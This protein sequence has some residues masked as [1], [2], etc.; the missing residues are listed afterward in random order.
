[1]AGS[2]SSEGA[3]GGS[4]E[5]YKPPSGRWKLLVAIAA[6][7]VITNFVTGITAYY[8]AQPAAT[9]PALCGGGGGVSSSAAPAASNAASV[10]SAEDTSPIFTFHVDPPYKTAQATIT[11]IGPWAPGGEFELFRPVLENFTAATGV[12]VTYENLRQE[13]LTTILPAQFASGQTPGDVIFMTTSFIKAN[14]QHIIKETGNISDSDFIPGSLD[15]VKVGSDPYGGVYTG[16]VKPGFWYRKSFFAAHNL[17]VPTTYTDFKALLVTISKIKGIRTPIVSGDSVGWPL[18]DIVEHFIATYG[19]ASMHRALTNGTKHWTDPDVRAIF[20][21]RL[22]P[23]LAGGCFSEP[24][25]WNTVA[26]TNW[27]GNLHALYF[28]GSWITGLVP[29]P[30]D[31]G[32]FSLPAPAGT[33]TGIVFGGD[34]FFVPKY[35]AHLTEAQQL[36]SYLASKDGQTIQV[37]QGGHIA[38]A[39]GVPLSDYPAVDR[40][41]AQLMNGVQILSDLDDSIGGQFQTN[42]WSQLQL[43]WVSPGQLDAVLASIQSKMPAS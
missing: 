33:T 9:T 26:L 41:V 31:L 4:T 17:T 19:G 7:L 38:T 22:T 40:G 15:P 6:L 1:M 37:E 18:S 34:Y 36:F 10:V 39:L 8:L 28:M 23:L 42:L 20:T 25:E 35:T 24:L 13:Q 3:S 14:P 21:D 5:A 30:S 29:D 27:W 11:V 12:P 43:L 32:V 16:K 2:G